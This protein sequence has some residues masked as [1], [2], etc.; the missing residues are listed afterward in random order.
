[1]YVSKYFTNE[2][3]DERL[4]QG[5]YDDFVKAGFAGTL[6]EFLAFVLSISQKVDK[7]D[8][9]TLTSNDFT[10]ELKA[11]LDGIEERANYI[12]KV[13]QLEND[14]GYQTLEDVNKVISNL[15]DGADDALDTLKE[16]AEA[17]GNDPNFATTITNKLTELRQEL[18]NEVQRAKDAETQLGN[19]ITELSGNI[20][21]ELQRLSDKIEQEIRDVNSS[22]QNL[23]SKV[24]QDIRDLADL[25]VQH[26]QDIADTQTKAK[27][28]TD[29]E[30]NRA[31]EAEQTLKDSI[32]NLSNTHLQDKTDLESKIQNET[33]AREQGDQRLDEALTAETQARILADQALEAAYKAADDEMKKNFVSFV[34]VSNSQLPHR[35]AIILPT[36]GDIFLVTDANGTTHNAFQLNRW[37]IF[38]V[39]A[40][41]YPINFNTPKGVRPTVQEAG[42]SGDQ[43]HKIAYTSDVE[44]WFGSITLDDKYLNSAVVQFIPSL[45]QGFV[46]ELGAP[47]IV[48]GMP[49]DPQSNSYAI[50]KSYIAIAYF[51]EGL[52]MHYQLYLAQANYTGLVF[53]SIF[54]LAKTNS[55]DHAKIREE[56]SNIQTGEEGLKEELLQAIQEEATARE[57]GDQNLQDT[58]VDKVE[59]YG[60]SKND[61]T[62]KLLNKLAGIEEGANKITAVSQLLNDLKFQTEDEVKASIESIIGSAPEVLDTLEEIAKALGDDPNFASTITKKMAALAE[63]I[64]QETE[65]RTAADTT[66]QGNIDSLKSDTT[67][68]LTQLQ[69]TL[70]GNINTEVSNRQS[71]DSQLQANLDSEA[72]QRQETD[73]QLLS[74][75]NTEA[76]NRQSSDENL[77]GQITNLSTKLTDL[78]NSL[79]DYVDQAKTEWANQLSQRDVLINQNTANIQRNLEL[80]QGLQKSYD[81]I[82]EQITQLQIKLESEIS[83]RKKADTALQANIDKVAQDLVT[84][85]NNRTAQDQILDQKIDQEIQDRKA[86][87]EEV[88]G[89]LDGILDDE[90]QA[91]IEGD[92]KLQDQL[93]TLPSEIRTGESITNLGVSSIT[94]G[95]NFVTKGADGKYG[96]PGNNPVTLPAATNATAGLMTSTDKTNLDNTVSGLAQ[97]IINRQNE[98]SQLQDQINTLKQQHEDEVTALTNRIQTLESKVGT[99]ETQIQELINALTLK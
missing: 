47:D 83:D 78:G 92:K 16:L 79:R 33:T 40:A 7:E 43:A 49:Y 8:G 62:D 55:E 59:G 93:D 67:T 10:D 41:A 21:S 26:T 28:Y 51:D 75:I 72:K 91:R 87:I 73:T 96:S 69:S 42:Q 66:L 15:V 94:I 74:L 35:K 50:G 98:D 65:D 4:L 97:E 64:N 6:Q 88:K 48:N 61:F 86:A 52:V 44:K 3:I 76:S 22:I 90:E 20:S 27:E 68:R 77:Q 37:N 85:T 32:S 99:L 12:T 38:D 57:Q 45:E 89:S 30:T 19:Q 95:H 34:D 46:D 60:L 56:I 81:S 2:E 63:D 71:A 54:D 14:K 25:R 24:D 53:K 80:I 5:Y 70:Q 1:M 58:K 39:G 13:S 36:L 18:L 9:K 31:K 82:V 84:E 11:K 17:L 29:A 23:T